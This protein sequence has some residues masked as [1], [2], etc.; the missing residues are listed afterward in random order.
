M[1]KAIFLDRDGTVIH[2]KKY[3]ADPRGVKLYA[4][5]KDAFAIFTKLGFKIFIVSNQSGVGRG[6]FDETAVK[7]VNARAETL[8]KPYIIEETVYCPHAPEQPCNCRKPRPALG[9]ALIKKY[10]I[11]PRASY[12]IGD[13]KS[14]VDFGRNLGMKSILVLTANGGAQL[15]KYGSALKADYTARTLL[16]AA[17]Y[18]ERGENEK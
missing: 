6:Y 8:L 12:M 13:K 11:D 1:T 18:I 3:L 16:K 15:K 9:M 2:D 17:K 14:D 4:G 10:K 5:A 7:A